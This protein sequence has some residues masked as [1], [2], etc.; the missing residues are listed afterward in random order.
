ML[1]VETDSVAG[2]VAVFDADAPFPSLE[3]FVLVP[4]AQF[5]FGLGV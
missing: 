5:M 2:M 3:P 4:K 1:V